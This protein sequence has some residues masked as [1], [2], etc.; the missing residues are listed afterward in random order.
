MTKMK[1]YPC[2]SRRTYLTLLVLAALTAFGQAQLQGDVSMGYDGLVKVYVS[3]KWTAVCT[4][5]D[6]TVQSQVLCRSFGQKFSYYS[7]RSSSL[8]GTIRGLVCRGDENSLSACSD[9]YY[10]SYDCSY[11]KL[12]VQCQE[13]SIKA[14]CPFDNNICEMV[15]EGTAHYKWQRVNPYFSSGLS[16]QSVPK[17]D[18]TTESNNGKYMLASAAGFPGQKAIL[19]TKPFVG[20]IGSVSFY[21]HMFGNDMGS[22]NVY[23]RSNNSSEKSI[24]SISG[25]QGIGWKHQCLPIDEGY[26]HHEVIFEAIQGKGFD[27]DI[28]LDDVTIS[29]NNCS[30][31]WNVSCDFV[32][33]ICDYNIQNIIDT[34][35]GWRLHSNTKSYSNSSSG[36]YLLFT[37]SYYTETRH[38][39][40][41]PMIDIPNEKIKLEFF[42]HMPGTE[43][44]ELQV[45]FVEDKLKSWFTKT[46]YFWQDSGDRG[47]EWQYGCM[48]LPSKRGRILFTGIAGNRYSTIGLDDLLVDK[49]Y[50]RTGITNHKC[51]FDNPLLCEYEITCM[52]PNEYTWRRK[53]GATPS[54]YTG[55]N[56]DNSKTGNGYYIYAEASYGNFNDTTSLKFPVSKNTKGKQLKFDYNM[57][58]SYVGQLYVVFVTNQS[59]T[60]EIVWTKKGDKGKYWQKACWHIENDISEIIFV[61]VRG[62]SYQG[63]IAIDNVVVEEKGCPGPFDCDFQVGICNYKIFTYYT[64]S[65]YIQDDYSYYSNSNKYLYIYSR[66]NTE[67]AYFK[68]VSPQADVKENSSVTFK[69]QIRGNM[70]KFALITYDY[71][72]QNE[73][74]SS[75]FNDITEFIT[76][77]VNFPNSTTFG[78]IFQGTVNVN[79]YWDTNTFLDDIEIHNETCKLGLTYHFCKF[80]EVHLCNFH[81]ECPENTRYNWSQGSSSYYN[82]I[83]HHHHY[84]YDKFYYMYVDSINGKPGDKTHLSFPNVVP[85]AGYSLYFDYYLQQGSGKLQIELETAN[86]K[87]LVFEE[88]GIA[89]SSV[90]QSACVQVTNEYTDIEFI[91]SHG[92]GTGR[93]IGLTNVGFLEEECQARN[94][95][96]GFTE[97]TCQYSNLTYYSTWERINSRNDTNLTDGK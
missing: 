15:S 18:H 87:E 58:G 86:G 7:S 1:T 30:S 42:Y 39:I 26:G 74:W 64:F 33:G 68:I 69:Y 78:L 57:Y 53:K 17:N 50:C 31:H 36:N 91:A 63:D 22:L 44:H 37:S 46:P 48:D 14:F 10:V 66:T 88:C 32:S 35:I 56:S 84:S 77:C 28:A 89:P 75:N 59:S 9:F 49:G 43:A 23:V 85:P 3:G 72:S 47:T 29:E 93:Y 67:N 51:T 12:H 82:G 55:P 97:G 34:N 4:S 52:N 73:L 76:A 83:P 20:N 95:S 16:V 94:I 25:N 81:V 92:Y 2:H 8:P 40:K 96:C 19:K 60:E 41:S 45:R 61:A 80:K 5:G 70:K 62:N 38:S 79:S 27:S 65:W 13:D 54:S 90:W 6:F 24:G 11:N 71:Y 21:Y